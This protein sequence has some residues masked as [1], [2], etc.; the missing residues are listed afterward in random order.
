MK[1]RIEIELGERRL[2]FVKLLAKED[3]LTIRQ[4]LAQMLFT[5]IDQ[6]IEINGENLEN[7]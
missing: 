4:E 2:N 3:G 5:E 6:L 1:M 7:Y